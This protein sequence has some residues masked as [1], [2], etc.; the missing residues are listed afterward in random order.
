[1]NY[2]PCLW[3]LWDMFELK[4]ADFVETIN[5]L[6]QVIQFHHRAEAGFPIWDVMTERNREASKSLLDR[7]EVHIHTLDVP[8]TKLTLEETRLELANNGTLKYA[9]YE[10]L[11]LALSK[12]LTRELTTKKI[13]VLEQCKADFFDPKDPL[14]GSEVATRFISIAY[15]IDQSGKCYAC[16]LSTAS[17]FHSIRC[18]EAGIRAVSRCLGI[19]DPTTGAQR[20]WNNA[21]KSIK[22]E[23]DTRW[24]GSA[25]KMS[26]DGKLFDEIHGDRLHPLVQWD[27]AALKDRAHRYRELLAA[28]LALVNAWAVRLAVQYIVILAYA[29]AVRADRTIGPA[30]SFKV[31]AGLGGVLEMRLVEGGH[32]RSP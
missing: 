6:Q 28:V 9:E 32:G 3:S 10:Q 24:P 5:I 25:G 15:E 23:I 12:T 4:A 13:Y 14:F 27:L 2:T 18:L 11:A 8:V 30:G 26:G 31:F 29:A 22:T 1:M 19:P 7:L 17:A 16:D 21:L 20:N